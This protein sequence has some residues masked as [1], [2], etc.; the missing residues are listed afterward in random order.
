MEFQR[1]Y[2]REGLAAVGAA[3]DDEGWE[4]VRPYITANPIN[5]PIVIGG[6]A[7]ATSYDVTSIPVTFLIDRQGKIAARHDGLVN[8]AVVEGEIQRL[9]KEKPSR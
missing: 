5:Y 2:G 1:T 4:K 9:L 3:M 8:R 7:L 6:T